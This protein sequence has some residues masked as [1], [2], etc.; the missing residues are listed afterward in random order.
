MARGS[1]PGRLRPSR[2]LPAAKLRD[3]AYIPQNE[4][5]CGIY[6]AKNRKRGI[7]FSD[8]LL[9]DAIYAAL[10]NSGLARSVEVGL[11]HF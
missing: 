9:L 5:N 2:D 6:C 8:S 3:A 7:Y 11:K 4:A 10:E 1:I